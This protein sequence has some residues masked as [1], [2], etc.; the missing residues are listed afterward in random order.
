MPAKVLPKVLIVDDMPANITMLVGALGDTY[1][2]Q[3]AINGEEALEVVA[4]DPPD[5]IL[6]DVN[7]PLLSGMEVCRRLKARPETNGIPIIFVTGLDD[8]ED[9]LFGL[10]LGAADYV[11]RPYSIPILRP[12]FEPI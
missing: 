4:D 11:T 7:M 5:I 6:L 9:E 3:V 8:E 1:R 12:G 2:L 10:G